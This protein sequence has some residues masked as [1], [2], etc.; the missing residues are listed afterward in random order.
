[1]RVTELERSQEPLPPFAATLDAIGW[2]LFLIW[3]GAALFAQ[4]GWP[5]FFVGTGA[6]MLAGQGARM[7][8]G[9]RVDWFALIL[10]TFLVLAGGLRVLDLQLDDALVPAWFVPSMF[11][12]IGVAVVVTA[13]RRRR[14]SSGPPS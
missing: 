12:A 3:V 4:V 2:G 10:G 5:V 14:R 7:S 6:L 8:L 11:V 1:M 13:W 9:A